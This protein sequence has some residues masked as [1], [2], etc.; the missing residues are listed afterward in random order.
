MAELHKPIIGILASGSGTTAEAVIH[1][2]QTPVLAAEVGLVVC[3]NSREYLER[4]TGDGGIY[5]K[6][7]RINKQYGLDIHVEKINATTHPRGPNHEGEMTNGEADAI[8]KLMD[9]RGVGLVA[10][11]GYSKR[12]MGELIDQYGGS[13]RH[14]AKEEARMINTHPGPLPQTRGLH[15]IDVQKRVLEL[16]LDYTAQTLHVVVGPYDSGPIIAVHRVPVMP[17]DTEQKLETAVQAT[18]KPWVPVDIN[19]YLETRRQQGFA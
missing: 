6:V 10:M 5:A 16:G 18:E 9:D 17:G 7:D 12:G 1:A 14:V 19:A 2:T 11:L 4:T 8:C 15:G 3:N 13:I